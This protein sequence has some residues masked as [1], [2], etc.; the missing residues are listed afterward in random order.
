VE[1]RIVVTRQGPPSIPCECIDSSN[2][3]L[4]SLAYS[5]GSRRGKL[6]PNRPM[7]NYSNALSSPGSRSD[8]SALSLIVLGLLASDRTFA[9]PIR[10]DSANQKGFLSGSGN[11]FMQV[12]NREIALINDFSSPFQQSQP[13]VR[14]ASL[15]YFVLL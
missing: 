4:T 6:A 5:N 2:V 7:Q 11:R 13:M 8:D 10:S 14:G 3:S 15:R 12:P 9:A 1:A